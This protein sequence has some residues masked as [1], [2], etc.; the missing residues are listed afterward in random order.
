MS[1]RPGYRVRAMRPAELDAGLL[2]AWR[3]LEER[4]LE[5]N[6]FLSPLFVVPAIRHLTPPAEAERV[7][8]LFVERD[9]AGPRGL[10]AAC[11]L[12]RSRASREFPLPHLRMYRSRHSYLSGFLVDRDEA[13]PALRDLF[14]FLGRQNWT[15][16]GLALDEYPVDGGQAALVARFA[17]EAGFRW[18]ERSSTERAFLVPADG[19]EA[20]LDARLSSNRK[21]KLR[22]TRRL[23]EAEGR[24]EWRLVG[25]RDADEACIERFLRVEHDGWKVD[26]GTS[27]L[28]QEADA[29]FCREAMRS[30]AEHGRLFFAEL[31]LGGQVIASISNFLAQDVGFSFKVGWLSQYARMGLGLFN[32][33]EFVRHAPT[34]CAGIRFIDSGA[35]AG[36]YIEHFWPGR[37][38]LVRGTFACTPLGGLAARGVAGLRA[39]RQ[40]WRGRSGPVASSE[41]G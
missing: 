10:V 35:G 39:A 26:E 3:A 14:A 18:R 5:P 16:H 2:E 11:A 29:A 38:R 28:S 25:G 33:F 23:L 34:A 6:A 31:L 24:L 8:V 37:R 40:W 13:E 21:K 7:R 20:L 1:A 22:R 27:I 19:G 12:E 30:F 17:A 32:E 4:A 36:S 15:G 41:A 9:G